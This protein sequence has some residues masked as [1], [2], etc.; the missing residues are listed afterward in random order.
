MLWDGVDMRLTAVIQL[1]PSD[2]KEGYYQ[3]WVD[4]EIFGQRL[5]RWYVNGE[6]ELTGT[7]LR[8]VVVPY[9]FY[10]YTI[11]YPNGTAG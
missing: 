2:T 8:F 7:T 10:N 5:G 9:D 11:R 6:F 4:P 3:F 1:L